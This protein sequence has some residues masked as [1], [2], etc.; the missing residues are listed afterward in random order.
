VNQGKL[1]IVD[2]FSSG[3]VFA[4][5]AKERHGVD[6]IAVI[7]SDH[8][9]AGLT[10]SYSPGDFVGEVAC[11]TIP[12]TV[13]SVERLCGGAPA[14]ILCGSEPGVEVFDDLAEHW[15]LR[16]NSG[17]SAPRRDKFLMQQRLLD[18]GVRHIPHHRAA[19]TESIVEWCERSGAAEYVVKPLRSFG[20]DGVSFC[21]DL[22]QVRAACGKLLGSA[23]FSG[24]TIGEVLVEELITG[25][26]F[27]VDSVSLDG[28]HFVVNMFRY[29]KDVVDGAPVYRTMSS[30]EVGDHPEIAEYVEQ[31]LTALGI[32]QGAAHSEVIVTADGPTLV[33]TG[34]RMHGGQ[35]P[36]LVEESSTHSLI[37]LALAARIA[38]DDFRWQT[39]N[40]PR[41]HRGVV[42]CFLCAPAAGEVG[43]N[44]VTELCRELDSYLFDTCRQVPGEYVPKTAD[45][46]TSYGRVVLA[47]VDQAALE[48]DARRVLEW[49]RQGVLLEVKSS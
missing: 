19:D 17:P 18:A 5:R 44:R 27:V 32:E 36:R 43:A 16:P 29:A 46:L 26:E 47:N 14:F 10:A 2:P 12:E 15:G 7:T 6:S 49:D 8:L 30:V 33:E 21:T 11:T 38:P 28:R 48:R 34:A 9:P 42:E 24:E 31:V 45:L 25:P 39:R 23:D 4:R 37:D 40:R 1:V 3:G 35:G 13:R 20:T 22:A 41:V